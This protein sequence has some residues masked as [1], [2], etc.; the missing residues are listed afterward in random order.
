MAGINE[1][2]GEMEGMR[3]GPRQAITKFFRSEVVSLI[4]EFVER[5][6]LSVIVE[7]GM[8]SNNAV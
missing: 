6:A 5:V 7:G 4:P 1:I 8:G 3:E 2:V